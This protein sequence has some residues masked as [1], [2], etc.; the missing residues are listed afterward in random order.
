MQQSRLPKRKIAV[1]FYYSDGLFHMKHEKEDFVKIFEK[2]DTI[3]DKG[4]D[5]KDFKKSPSK[6]NCLWC[7]YKQY[8]DAYKE[9]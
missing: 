9:E 3:L 1:D 5:V 4:T 6:E 8:C 7:N 2:V